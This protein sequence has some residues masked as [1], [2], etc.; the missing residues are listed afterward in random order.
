MLCASATSAAPR[1]LQDA[2]S[3]ADA[4]SGLEHLYHARTAEARVAFERVRSRNPE[5]PA[6]DFLL[7]GIAWHELTT[8]PE[9]FTG[10]GPEEK[11][12]FERMGAAIA[13]GEKAIALDPR[14]V[15][16]RFFLGG[17]YGYEARYLALQERWWDAYRTGRKGLKHLERVAQDAPDLDDAYLGL[18]IYH[19]YADVIPSV[20]KVLAGIVGLGGDRAR[21]LDEI[22]RALRDGELVNV[23]AA[24]F[25]AEIHT[26]FE[27]DHWTALGYSQSLRGRYPENELFTWLNARVLDELHLTELAAREWRRLRATPRSTAVR[28]FLDYRLAR[29]RLGSGDFA[30]AAAELGDLLERD[31][32]GSR[33]ITMWGRLRYGL[34]LDFLGRHAEAMK[35]YRIAKELDA[36]EP[37]EERAAARLAAGARDARVVSLPELAETARIL[38]ETRAQGEA[39]IRRIENQVVG[40]SRGLAKS[41][42]RA[43]FRILGDLALARLVR[44]DAKGC[45]AAIDRA[46]AGPPRPPKEARPDLLALRARARLRSGRVAAGLEDLR[47]ARSAAAGSSRVRFERERDL[48]ARAAKPYAPATGEGT[49]AHAFEAPDRGEIAL[50][51]EGDF[52]AGSERLR[53]ALRDGRWSG[54]ARFAAPKTIRYRFVADAVAR[55]PDPLAE[56]T[57][58]L[59]DEFWC[60][61]ASDAARD[62]QPKQTNPSPSR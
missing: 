12:F 49:A 45:E 8:G 22:R 26:T 15:S 57:E 28:G 31:R 38:R 25:L 13:A 56:R 58:I 50:E 16:A 20:L 23:E 36:S 30:G 44:G 2:Q 21:G 7:G 29:T 39:E 60:V 10:S 55:R 4:R 27:E 51:V 54:E 46:L 35:Q 9:G 6:A 59:G 48:V 1:P 34:A 17:A 41:D 40:P 47:A 43:F 11:E 3:L 52:L 19:Y 61:R 53:L 24:F 42:S 5:S 18:G 62:A 33:R 37:A 14:D 32:L